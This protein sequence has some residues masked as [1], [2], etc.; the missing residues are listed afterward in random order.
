MASAAGR[1]GLTLQYCMALPRHFLQ[2]VSYEEVT[3]LRVSDDRFRPEEWD[4]FLY[5]SRLASAVGVWPWADVFMSTER[6]NLLL[7]T[8]SGGIV[9]IGDPLG[10]ESPDNLRRA[11][12]ADGVIVKPDVPIA[13]IDQTYVAEAQEVSSPMVA[14]SFTNHAG[15][16]DLYVFAYR[17][18]ASPQTI[19]VTPADLGLPGPAYVD[20][21]FADTGRLLAAGDTFTA[22]AE[23]GAYYVVAPLGPSG[24]AFLGDAGQF[25]SLGRKRVS[26]LTDDGGLHATIEFAANEGALTLHGFAAVPPTIGATGGAIDALVYDPATQRFSFR[27]TP[28]VTPSSVSIMLSA[29]E[30]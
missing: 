8:L 3:S 24:V 29:P 2:S 26:E 4:G 1:H 22:P 11:I 23:D 20:D 7:A 13:P 9:G 21:V 19:S 18:G 30:H 27:L 6:T 5:G 25:V 10:A 12:R 15:L 17:R 16:L 28:L 14:A